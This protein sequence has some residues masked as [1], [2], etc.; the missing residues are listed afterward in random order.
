MLKKLIACFLFVAVGM[1]YSTNISSAAIS[2]QTKQPFDSKG[3]IISSDVS[4]DVDLSE[5][6]FQHQTLNKQK[7]LNY[8]DT[9]PDQYESN[10]TMA[11]ATDGLKGSLVT[12][13]LHNDT[14]FDWYQF[15]LTQEEINN[16]EYYSIILD[17]I[18]SGLNYK[19][20]L[21]NAYYQG[22]EITAD[23]STATS[24]EFYFLASDLP[25]NT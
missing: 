1:M 24:K 6:V 15:S 17:N 7:R 20:Y 14:D 19:L 21:V 2:D 25:Q 18:P 4:F 5:D 16:N 9:T 10:D 23:S 3:H 11:T 8:R 12:A 22:L 13:N